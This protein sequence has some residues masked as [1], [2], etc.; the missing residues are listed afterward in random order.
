MGLLKHKTFVFNVFGENTYIAYT[1]N[2]DAAIIDPG[3]NNTAECAELE[4]FI[5]ANQLNPVM[6]LNTHAHIDHVLGNDFIYSKYGLL[7]RLH[8]NELVILDALVYSSTFYGVQ[9]TA[10]PQPVDFLNEG[11]KLKL[12][13]LEFEVIFAPGHSPGGLCF[14]FASEKVL[15]CGDVLFRESIGRTDLPGG[16]FETLA[17]NIQTKL[18]TLPDDVEVYSGHGI[19]TTIGYEKKHNPFVGIKNE[20]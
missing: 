15:F 6:L 8:R 16:N 14:Y 7:P 4:G 2:G 17:H 11:D 18:Y 13:G 1:D 12:G 5:K 19:P 20:K 10:S 3:C 9:A